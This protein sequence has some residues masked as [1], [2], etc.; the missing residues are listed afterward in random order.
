[1]SPTTSVACFDRASSMKRPVSFCSTITTGRPGGSDCRG[2]E[3]RRVPRP[4]S[5]MWLFMRDLPRPKICSRRVS[6]R[7][8]LMKPKV[9]ASNAALDSMRKMPNSLTAGGACC[10][11]M[12][13]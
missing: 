4:Q 6:A 10:R 3:R 7:S 8:R 13:P 9:A 11:L 2:C 5:T 1:M 12:S